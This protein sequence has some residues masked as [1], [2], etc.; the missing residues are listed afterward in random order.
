V[1]ARLIFE[2]VKF[3]ARNG[4]AEPSVDEFS[5]GSSASARKRARRTGVRGE[6]YAYWYLRRHGYTLVARNYTFPGFKGEIDMVGYDGSVLAFVEVKTR[7]RAQP[8]SLLPLPEDAV[9]WEKRRNL[10]RM[11][12]QFLQMR[13]INSASHRFDIL[14][15]EAHEGTQPEVRLLKDAFRPHQHGGRAPFK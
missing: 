6:T 9:N 2:L 5:A 11:A 8:G 4:L 15:I 10:T 12:Q 13:R 7:S 14:A 1:F 3:G